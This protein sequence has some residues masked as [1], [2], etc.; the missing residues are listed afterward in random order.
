MAP[1]RRTR[2]RDEM[3][4]RVHASE[5]SSAEE[6]AE[7]EKRT[8]LAVNILSRLQAHSDCQ[9]H[10]GHVGLHI[11]RDG[12]R[13][14]AIGKARVAQAALT[15][16][17]KFSDTFVLEIIITRHFLKIRERTRLVTRLGLPAA[18]SHK[19]LDSTKHRGNTSKLKDMIDTR[20]GGKGR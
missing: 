5:K 9:L 12:T 17:K 1:E 2:T 10:V 16:T 3:G 13:W 4:L 20:W 7:K 15:T 6:R 14:A 11:R 19:R 8:R 18:R